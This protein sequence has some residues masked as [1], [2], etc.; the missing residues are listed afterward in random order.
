MKNAFGFTE[1]LLPLLAFIL[2]IVFTAC[3]PENTIIEPD[4]DPDPNPSTDFSLGWNQNSENLD[5]IPQDINLGIGNGGLPSSVDLRENFPPT[6]NQG[7]YGTCVAWAVGYNLKTAL[8]AMDKGFKT[9]D[10]NSASRQFSPKDLF[11]SIPDNQKGTDCN[12][13][14]FEP[15]MDVMINRGIA[16][17][18]SVP[19][20]GL[21][22]C[23][24]SNTGGESEAAGYQISN[25][26]K[27]DVSVN[28]IKSYLADNRPIAIGC[29]LGDN[30]MQ[31]NSDDVIS[32]HSSFNNV[33]QHA[34]HAMVAIGYDDNKGPRGAFRVL[35]SWGG[36]WG[37]IGHIWVDYDFFVSPEFC[38]AAFVA[39]NKESIDPEDNPVDPTANGKG[40]L[41][42]WNLFD[43]DDEQDFD[44]TTRYLQYNVY[45]IGDEVIRASSRW[46]VSYVY[47]NA[48]DA[49]DYGIILYDYY[50]NEFGN[51]G[52]DGPL[53]TGGLGSSGNWWNHVD[54]P[55]N[56]G[57]AEEI[58]G[59]DYFYWN[60][61][62]P[63]ITGYYYLVLIA[64]TFDDV[65]EQDESNNLYYITNEWGGP[66]YFENGTPIGL[67]SDDVEHRSVQHPQRGQKLKA[68]H[69]KSTK[70]SNMYTPEEIT[71]LIEHEKANGNLQAK[72][73]QFVKKNKFDKQ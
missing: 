70:T 54:L 40:E 59:T 33:G 10:L 69:Q 1:K 26:R 66:V 18:Q 71:G 45:N 17:M 52:E 30:F 22:D 48:Y 38:F 23:R 2:L 32:S 42:P 62:V 46:S 68:P 14:N 4:P 15:A 36:N 49:E 16:T 43:G 51:P 11:W 56:S 61:T 60:Y 67:Q 57:L 8:E 5:E 44:P 19:Y 24:Q 41:I 13:T 34:Y 47:Y 50:T 29:K 39:T 21:G 64:D 53:N 35:N 72:V 25:Y 27:I 20:D 73:S 37:D 55:A 31:W 9:N 7:N 28:T 63:N 6:G 3:D 58:V 12:G 65:P